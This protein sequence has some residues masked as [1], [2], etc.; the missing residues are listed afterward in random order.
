MSGCVVGYCW[1]H[2][3][4]SEGK[5]NRNSIVSVLV[6]LKHVIFIVLRLQG[7]CWSPTT[8]TRW[9]QRWR[10]RCTS[11]ITHTRPP[12]KSTSRLTPG[13]YPPVPPESC[14]SGLISSHAPGDGLLK[15][16]RATYPDR[17]RVDN[18]FTRYCCPYC[19]CFALLNR[20]PRSRPKRFW[21]AYASVNRR[22]LVAFWYLV[23]GDDPCMA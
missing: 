21:I 20:V 11:R 23:H 8:T 6:A 13:E 15:T 2:L 1:I 7:F 14:F 17:S 18:G 3:Q 22:V 10:C 16:R 5:N 9:T 12:S 19:A 4:P